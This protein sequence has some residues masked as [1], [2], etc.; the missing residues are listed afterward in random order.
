MV[1]GESGQRGIKPKVRYAWFFEPYRDAGIGF[2]LGE[3]CLRQL[4][5]LGPDRDLVPHILARIRNILSPYHN[6]WLEG[7]ADGV[8]VNRCFNKH[9]VCL[10]RRTVYIYRFT[11]FVLIRFRKQDKMNWGIALT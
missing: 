8:D 9:P 5:E 1:P 6:S 7:R 4:L 10:F 11:Q 3:R 2:D